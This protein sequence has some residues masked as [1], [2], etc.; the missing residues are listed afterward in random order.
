MMHQHQILQLLCQLQLIYQFFRQ[1]LP[2]ARPSTASSPNPVP[3]PTSSLNPHPNPVT[4]PA[5]SPNPGTVPC[6]TVEP[7]STTP[8]TTALFPRVT[9]LPLLQLL[10]ILRLLA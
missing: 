2:I 7:S 1:A 3:N 5:S 10:S 9:F 4:N 8:S 6:T